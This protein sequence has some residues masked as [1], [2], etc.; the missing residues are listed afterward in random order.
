MEEETGEGID[1]GKGISLGL[2]KD[3][4]R[5]LNP[6]IKHP[7]FKPQSLFPQKIFKNQVF[8]KN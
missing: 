5:G 2:H 6:K 3:E 4:L 8:G 7:K 1:L